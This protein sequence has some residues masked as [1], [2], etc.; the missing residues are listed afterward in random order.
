MRK[1]WRGGGGEPK[2][3]SWLRWYRE[4]FALYFAGMLLDPVPSP[5]S[6]QPAEAA[7]SPSAPKLYE[8]PSAHPERLRPDVPL[9]P[10]EIGLE[11]ELGLRP[12]ESPGEGPTGD[13]QPS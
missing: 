10:L 6:G 3:R 8:P 11:Q 1:R 12:V 2:W 5:E 4:G 13:G 9:T 7:S